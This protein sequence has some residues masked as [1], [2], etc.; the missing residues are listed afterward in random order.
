MS[1]QNRITD[2]YLVRRTLRGDRAAFEKL[3]RKYLDTAYAAAYASLGNTADAEDAAQEAF[4]KAYEKLD[5]LRS[6]S[7]FLPWLLTIVRN[8]CHSIYRQRM[9]ESDAVSH[10]PPAEA[11]EPQPGSDELHAVIRKTVNE[12][13]ETSRTV[14]LL[15]YF[16][17]QNTRE[18]AHALDIS[19]P[20][21]K[22]R[23]E[24]ARAAL[25]RELVAEV[26]EAVQPKGKRD[27]R[28]NIIVAAAAG[29][30]SVWSP[31]TVTA[32]GLSP[33]YVA[34]GVAAGGAMLVAAYLATNSD[35]TKIVGAGTVRLPLAQKSEQPRH[36]ETIEPGQTANNPEN[37]TSPDN[38][39]EIASEVEYELESENRK[40]AI[41]EALQNMMTLTY[42]GSHI[43]GVLGLVDNALDVPVFADWRVVKKP[44]SKEDT[45]TKE[46]I[47]A[48]PKFDTYGVIKD[49]D[50]TAMP[51]VKV[52]DTIASKLDL[53]Y[54]V[55]EHYVWVSRQKRINQEFDS[56]NVPRRLPD[57]MIDQLASPITLKYEEEHLSTVVDFIRET[58]NV[59]IVLDYRVIA[60]APYWEVLVK[61][62][63]VTG[64]ISEVGELPWFHLYKHHPANHYLSDTW[65]VDV[66][67]ESALNI[68]T[69]TT[70][71]AY[72]VEDGFVWLSTPERIDSESFQSPPFPGASDELER[73]LTRN[74]SPSWEGDTLAEFLK[75]VRW[76]DGFN[77]EFNDPEIGEISLEDYAELD[78]QIPLFAYLNAI[79]RANDLDWRADGHN[80]I[81]ERAGGEDL[82]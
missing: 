75:N 81:I 52:L 12:L 64:Y 68:L 79:L 62:E 29:T 4:V 6:R 20:A 2:G 3:V 11:H 56:Q 15:Y 44:I 30:S 1:L 7:K 21:A 82:I 18:I 67:V 49:I 73:H 77:A 80:L 78:V 66:S 27:A 25:G 48:L 35:S 61:D 33:G 69:R 24:R 51:L 47:D 14:L 60:P 26:G 16:N 54:V 63:E 42:E 41:R 76:P 65:M 50:V 71:L 53:H 13:D 23:L 32:G 38:N 72:S 36:S 40:E 34:I 28:V 22:K 57:R 74:M 43:G 37:P 9:R 39:E 19:V 45:I 10:T 8:Q 55:L 58:L 46:D 31:G 59:S 70:N 17:G 5:T